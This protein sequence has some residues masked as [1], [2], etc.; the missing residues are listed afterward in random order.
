MCAVVNSKRIFLFCKTDLRA[1]WF[2]NI[3]YPFKDSV[4]IIYLS[5]K[6]DE[7]VHRYAARGEKDGE[8]ERNREKRERAREKERERVTG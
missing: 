7:N 1:F 3:F 2:T 8:R 4:S 5:I 6:K